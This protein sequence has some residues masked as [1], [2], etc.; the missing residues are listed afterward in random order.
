MSEKKYL[1]FTS[2]NALRTDEKHL[3]NFM[4]V[5]YRNFV[6][7]GVAQWMIEYDPITKTAI[8]EIGLDAN[9]Q[10]V[11]TAPTR[12]TH[13]MWFGTSLGLN[14]YKSFLCTEV[15]E[16]RFAHLFSEN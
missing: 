14:D 7:P 8:R 2:E 15:L 10:K 4:E 11:Y 13:G 3:R 12:K 1:T 5:S 16:S 9:G 6:F